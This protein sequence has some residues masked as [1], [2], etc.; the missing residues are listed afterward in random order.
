MW[1]LSKRCKMIKK[2]DIPSGIFTAW[3]EALCPR[4]WAHTWAGLVDGLPCKSYFLTR[5]QI[6]SAVC[7]CFSGRRLANAA[8]VFSLPPASKPTAQDLGPGP[9]TWDTQD[10][11][12]RS[13]Q[14]APTI[15]HKG[16][17]L[18]GSSLAL[19]R[20]LFFWTLSSEAPWAERDRR[21]TAATA[22]VSSGSP[23]KLASEEELESRWSWH[24]GAARPVASSAARHT[25][26]AAGAAHTQHTLRL[27]QAGLLQAPRD[28][29]RLLLLLLRWWRQ[30][31][32]LR[33]KRGNC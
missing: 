23:R 28:L 33:H 19:L 14:R 17:H 8:V 1:T 12:P 10:P 18:A 29:L 3:V 2:A 22:W 26:G 31:E 25:A 7:G 5:L 21:A 20:S 11:G 27:E 13:Q 6:S 15:P 32:G 30:W 9:S 4:G 16:L 24:L